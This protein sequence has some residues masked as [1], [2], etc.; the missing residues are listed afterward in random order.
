MI[1]LLYMDV[2]VCEVRRLLLKGYF[3][4]DDSTSCCKAELK[5]RLLLHRCVIYHT[6]IVSKRWYNRLR[7]TLRYL[8]VRISPTYRSNNCTVRWFVPGGAC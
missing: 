2:G 6:D 3:G 8:Y 4:K 1:S 5:P 7:A